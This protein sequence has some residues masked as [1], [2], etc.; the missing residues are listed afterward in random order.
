MTAEVE[1]KDSAVYWFF[2]L[3]VARK[4]GNRELAAEAKR[5][6]RRLGVE[7]SYH[8]DEAECAQAAN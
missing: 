5:E 2:A 7:I 1:V 4:R 3:E 8:R 6:L